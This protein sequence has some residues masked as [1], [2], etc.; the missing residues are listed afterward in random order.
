MFFLSDASRGT[1]RRRPGVQ[2]D[3]ESAWGSESAEPADES[4]GG[5]DEAS[6]ASGADDGDGSDF[7]ADPKDVDDD[8]PSA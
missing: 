8:D 1:D 6:W 5:E 3:G 2:L 7:E 4:W